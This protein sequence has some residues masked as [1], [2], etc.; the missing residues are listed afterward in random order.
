MK[1]Y[2]N[3]YPI[4]CSFEGLYEAFIEARKGKRDRKEVIK[5]TYNLG[6]NLT[7]LRSELIRKIYSVSRYRQF[8]IYR[9]KKR[10]IMA[11]PFKDRIVQWAIYRVLNPLLD[12]RYIS[13]SYACRVGYGSHK[14]VEQLQNWLRYLNRRYDRI[15]VLKADIA[16]YFYSVDHDV[17]MDIFEGII[18]D[19][20][21]LWLLETIIRCEHTSF[22]LPFDATDFSGNLVGGTGMPIGNLTSQMVA[23]LY[24]NELDQYVKHDLREKYYMRY[25]DDFLVLHHDKDHLWYAKERIEDFL[26]DNLRLRLNNKTCIR[27]HTQGTDWVGYRV[28]PTHIKL[29]KSTA[30]QMKR[31]LWHLQDIYAVDE[32]PIDRV[33]A[34][35]QSYM[36]M[37]KHCDSYN[38][39]EKLFGELV[40]SRKTVMEGAE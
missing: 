36:G 18:K 26:Y 11:L 3:L 9:P 35:V 6:D 7:S 31:W 23:N 27:T 25:N 39:R 16:K 21:L 22:G 30:K 37:L 8:F 40:F 5:Y 14:A 13:N 34:T 12:K 17:T 1:R 10:L 2:D 33:N 32:I 19:R 29:R 38:L 15:Y 24:M 20:D 28:W 4:V